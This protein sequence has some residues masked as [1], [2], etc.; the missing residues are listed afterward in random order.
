M[1]YAKRMARDRG[2]PHL[3]LLVDEKDKGVTPSSHSV[4]TGIYAKA[5]Y[6]FSTNVEGC[7]IGSDAYTA[8]KAPVL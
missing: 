2:L 5:D 3:Y 1:D 8:M 6:G 7:A 4:L